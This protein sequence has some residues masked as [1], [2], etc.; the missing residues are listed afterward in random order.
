MLSCVKQ[1]SELLGSSEDA[2]INEIIETLCKFAE[3]DNSG[4]GDTIKIQ[5]RKN[6]M[7]RFL[8]KSLQDGDPVFSKVSRAVYLAARG[9]V[10][11]GSGPGGRA[12]QK[13]PSG[14]WGR[15]LYSMR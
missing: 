4:D 8:T 10:L 14:R 9:V 12:L 7:A 1:L 3:S 5:S 2:G 13:W 11:G 15:V 6:I